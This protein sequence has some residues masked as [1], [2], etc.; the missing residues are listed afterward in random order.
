M[1]N[2]IFRIILN[3]NCRHSEVADRQKRRLKLLPRLVA[4]HYQGPIRRLRV[5]W[6]YSRKKVSLGYICPS[7]KSND[8]YYVWA[9][10]DTHFR[11]YSTRLHLMIPR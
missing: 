6:Q 1:I 10:I 5:Y 8:S 11:A 3:F 7:I 9:Y 2:F 4:D